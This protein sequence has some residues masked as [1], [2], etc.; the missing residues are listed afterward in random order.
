MALTGIIIETPALV[1]VGLPIQVSEYDIQRD[2]NAAGSWSVAFPASQALANQVRSR[3]RVSIVEEGRAGYLLRRGIVLQRNYRVNA[4]GTGVLTLAG[5][6]RLYA[7]AAQSTHLGLEYD[8]SQSIEDIANDLTGEIV[9]VPASASSRFPVVTFDDASK[10]DAL[11]RACEYVRYNLRETFESDD[12]YDEAGIELVEQD[13]VPDSGFRFITVEHAGPEIENAAASG[14]GL[15]AGAPTIGYDGSKLATRIIPIGQEFDG[16]P[17]TLQFT[18]T[19]TPYVRQVGTNPDSTNYYYVED[20]AAIEVSGV[21]E[22]NYFRTDV[23]NP[24]DDSGTRTAAANALYALA[25]A[26]LIRRRYDVIAFASEIA[27]GRHIDA[28]PGDRVRVQFRGIARTPSGVLTWQDID[29]D[30]LIVKRRDAS[31]AAGVRGV[32]FTLTAPEVPMVNPSLPDA[33]PIPG[34]PSDPPN[35]PEPRDKD[36]DGDDFNDGAPDDQGADAPAFEDPGLPAGPGL[37]ELIDP[38]GIKEDY[39]PCCGPKTADTPGPIEPPPGGEEPPPEGDVDFRPVGSFVQAYNGGFNDGVPLSF[40]SP[41]DDGQLALITVWS[42]SHG[43]PATP[44]VSSP[45]VSGITQVGTWTFDAGNPNG[46]SG[47]ERVTL[48]KGLIDGATPSDFVEVDVGSSETNAAAFVSVARGYDPA[49]VQVVFED[50]SVSGTNQDFTIPMAT[51]S[52]AANLLWSSLFVR[53]ND[54]G[55]GSSNNIAAP[56]ST[57]ISVVIESDQLPNEGPSF[58]GGTAA[59]YHGA[60]RDVSTRFGSLSG[61]ESPVWNVSAPGSGDTYLGGLAV[62]LTPL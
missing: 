8:G 22:A 19:A 3:W 62:E 37:P 59:H 39:Q 53:N 28:L 58:N 51:V 23:K 56:W 6:S 27:N 11:L 48:F 40:A 55:P 34:P 7:L 15:I 5:Y 29:A 16:T 33:V 57:R 30:F 14:I 42:H 12:D 9:A 10:L 61:D 24:S 18:T 49:L 17:L 35:P 36:R 26:E 54:A 38:T 31:T 46:H 44:T 45:V 43:S 52:D 50:G 32:S 20:A 25:C 41:S 1:E 4:D 13:D 47:T 21:V 60:S 2:L